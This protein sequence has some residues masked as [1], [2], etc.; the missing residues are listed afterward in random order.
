MLVVDVPIVA[1]PLVVLQ[2]ILAERHEKHPAQGKQ[3]R[4]LVCWR[5]VQGKHLENR[6]N[7]EPDVRSAME[8]LHEV[9]WNDVPESVF[10]G[11]HMVAHEG[12]RMTLLGYHSEVYSPVR[13]L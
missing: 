4:V 3:G 8:L 7:Q 1:P 12:A 13:L 2:S 9:S 10:G 6:H 5:D 11:C